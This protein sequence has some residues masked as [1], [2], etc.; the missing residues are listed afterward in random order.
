MA[1]LSEGT[2]TVRVKDAQFTE[3]KNGNIAVKLTFTN[4]AG[5]GDIISWTGTFVSEKAKEYTF[6]VLDTCGLKET[7]AEI[8]TK[9]AQAFD[10]REVE[11][12]VVKEPGS[13]PGKFFTKV[14]YV[15]PVGGRQ[16]QS[17]AKTAASPQM[18][19]GAALAKLASLGITDQYRAHKAEKA[20]NQNEMKF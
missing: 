13:E 12:V 15:N 5:G 7:P 20:T 10:G 4:S 6:G 1:I 11:V 17:K 8:V 9:G 3:T 2:H 14:K 16:F 19:Q 18:G